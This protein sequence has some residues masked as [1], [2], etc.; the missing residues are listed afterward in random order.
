MLLLTLS[1]YSVV[2]SVTVS[3]NLTLRKMFYY[4]ST[5]FTCA[6]TFYPAPYTKPFLLT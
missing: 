3:Q 5:N 2:I 1:W 6:H 4:P